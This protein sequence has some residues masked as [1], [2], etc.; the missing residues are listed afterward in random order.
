LDSLLNVLRKAVDPQLGIIRGVIE[1]PLQAADAGAFTFGAEFIG[2]ARLNRRA[3]AE[4]STPARTE[5]A[6]MSTASDTDRRRAVWATLGEAFERY[7]GSSFGLVPITLARFSELSQ[8]ALD[9]EQLI[10][11]S[12]E[13]YLRPGFP[14]ARFTRDLRHYWVQGQWL[15]DGQ[16]VLV[17]A[18]AVYL[19]C[20][21]PDAYSAVDFQY[22]TGLAAG[23][24]WQQAAL[25]GL[26]EVIERDA[27][28]FTWQL[29]RRVPRLYSAQAAAY[30]PD[31]PRR[32]VDAGLL[33]IYAFDI[34]T[35]IGVP[36]VLA[37]LRDHAHR[38]FA[39]GAA[40]H[41]QAQEA[42]RKAVLEAYSTMGWLHQ[43]LVLGRQPCAAAQD[44]RT[45]EDHVS[46]YMAPV[47]HEALRF[48]LD[49][50]ES[51]PL[52]ALQD[53]HPSL[54]DSVVGQLDTVVGCTV[55]AGFRPAFAH[56]TTT[57]LAELGLHAG[58]VIVPGLHPLHAGMHARHE[59]D[60]RLRALAA[61][62][63]IE[64]PPS[65]NPDPH[66]FP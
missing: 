6:R 25:S 32:H 35:D 18:A 9:P 16:A 36:V 14:F 63:G 48:L 28:M 29:R 5:A 45:F 42:V 47:R 41:P 13:Q 8:P 12:R 23:P 38:T 44:V 43:L 31:G 17:P 4:S 52:S 22:S 66:P 10:L 21:S 64:M 39:V 50:Q 53:A 19:N 15:D 40:A 49:T 58:R 56:V 20:P 11:Y 65:L 59:D 62:F 55:K 37:A 1:Q 33:E 26:C 34:R 46:Y 7:A 24:S 2:P 54:P 57:D 30:L 61:T 27:F 51:L 60:R 3:S